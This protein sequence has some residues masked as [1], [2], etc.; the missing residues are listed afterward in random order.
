MAEKDDREN[1]GNDSG[2]RQYQFLL[3]LSSALQDRVPSPGIAFARMIQ[4]NDMQISECDI[5]RC[6][7]FFFFFFSFAYSISATLSDKESQR[8]VQ[9]WAPI[10]N[11]HL[12]E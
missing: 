10:Y 4:S 1:L 7:F 6:F 2:Q 11:H 5:F 8:D 12:P 9:D 3:E